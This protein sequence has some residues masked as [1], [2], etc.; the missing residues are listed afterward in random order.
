[1][2]H[3]T[4]HNNRCLDST[5]ISNRFIDFYMK[6]A[7]DAQIKIYLYLVRMMNSNLP[8]SVTEIAD[9][10]NHTEKDVVRSLKYWE[11]KQLLA[12]EYN[13]VGS[14]VGISLKE[15]K[16][17][18]MEE[19]T[20]I[21]AELP[22][23]TPKVIEK[24]S[25][26]LDEVKTFTDTME[27]S[28]LLYV[29]EQLLGKTLSQSDIRSL[30]FIYDSLKF[31]IDLIDYLIQ[32]CADRNKKEFR[33]IESVARSWREQNITTIKEAQALVCNY[34]KS[35]YT[36]MNALGKSN[37]PTEIE[38]NYIKKWQTNLGFTQ[39]I[40]L[41]ACMRTVMNTDNN[42]FKYAN[43]ILESWSKQNVIYLKDVEECDRNYSKSPKITQLAT[44]SKT[45]SQFNNFS[46]NT[47]DFDALEKELISN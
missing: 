19:V 32:Y 21:T 40:I 5:L 43:S 11:N 4:I 18:T 38:I 10:F 31:P 24:D 30:Y 8:T 22:K 46:H 23:L 33:Y 3:L 7:N 16:E 20:S 15:L 29:T 26:S 42:R 34:D 27:I 25:Y 35:I 45:T 9:Q 37:K 39:D 41:E 28:E 1:M 14:L 6:E 12:L 47:Y 17:S 2:G 36:I 44:K 13:D